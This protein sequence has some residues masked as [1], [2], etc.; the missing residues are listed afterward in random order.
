MQ[1]FIIINGPKA[2]RF[3]LTLWKDTISSPID[4]F[5]V[6][7]LQAV[8]EDNFQA[9]LD[10]FWELLQNFVHPSKTD[11]DFWVKLCIQVNRIYSKA[12]AKFDSKIFIR[13]WEI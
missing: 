13:F 3:P 9:D 1:L 10:P 7:K 4:V 5:N 11:K 2:F 6:E 8:S 12:Y